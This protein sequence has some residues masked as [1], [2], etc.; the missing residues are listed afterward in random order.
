MFLAGEWAA[1]RPSQSPQR[2][3]RGQT[4]GASLADFQPHWQRH[5]ASFGRKTSRDSGA[6]FALVL[7]L[8]EA[9]KG[10][11]NETDFPDVLSKERAASERMKGQGAM[12]Q[13]TELVR[14]RSKVRT[15]F[16]E[17]AGEFRGLPQ[18]RL[19]LTTS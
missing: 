5:R 13:A 6:Y 8:R 14:G 19:V 15:G 3:R 9:A 2:C 11:R 10:R 4:R 18:R 7:I 1:G 16:L 17:P 12:V